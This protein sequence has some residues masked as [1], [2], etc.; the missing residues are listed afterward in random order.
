MTRPCGRA[1][2]RGCCAIFRTLTKIIK[3]SKGKQHL[4][5]LV[6]HSSSKIPSLNEVLLT[7]TLFIPCFWIKIL[8]EPLNSHLYAMGML[9]MA[10][11][12]KRKCARAPLINGRKYAKFAGSF[13]EKYARCFNSWIKD[14]VNFLIIAL[15]ILWICLKLKH[16]SIVRE[17]TSFGVVVNSEL[18]IL[19]EKN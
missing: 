10:R 4:Q 14:G 7:Y 13:N 18:T 9:T 3:I 11:K 6:R 15:T 17:N 19:P 16:P 8:I 2:A 5:Y 12:F 1:R